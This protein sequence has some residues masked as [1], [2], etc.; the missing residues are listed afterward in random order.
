M[1]E[2]SARKSK[3]PPTSNI[4]SWQRIR[5]I[6]ASIAF[7]LGLVAIIALITLF[8][9]WQTA[10][11]EARSTVPVSGGWHAVAPGRVE[12]LSSEVKITSV[13]AALV[14]EVLVK[15]NDNVFAGEP[16]IRLKDD[17]LRARRAASAAQVLSRARR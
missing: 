9:R 16:L 2:S 15:P 7:L 6:V 1:A 13:V 14:T 5:Q 3:M 11:L 4:L 10:T 8:I 12:P 17:E